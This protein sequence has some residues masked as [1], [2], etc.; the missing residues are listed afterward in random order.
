MLFRQFRIKAADGAGN[1]INII[2]VFRVPHIELYIV[3]HDPVIRIQ[4]Q[5]EVGNIFFL[6]SGMLHGYF[7]RICF[8]DVSRLS[9]DCRSLQ[10]SVRSKGDCLTC[11][12][13]RGIIVFVFRYLDSGGRR[14]CSKGILVGGDLLCYGIRSALAAAGGQK[15][16]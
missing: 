10:G 4:L 16:G 12:G 9:A 7:F 1:G 15:G 14:A 3:F 5:L 2:F 13:Q 11:C 6:D 8:T